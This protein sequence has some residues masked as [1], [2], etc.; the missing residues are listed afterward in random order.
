MYQEFSKWLER[1]LALG[2]P[3]EIIAVHFN[4]YEEANHNWSIQF[5][6]TGSFDEED[7]DWACDEVFSTGEDLYRWKK[8]TDWESALEEGVHMVQEYLAEGTYA[9]ML[10]KYRAVG[11]GFVDG[12]IEVLYRNF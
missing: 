2:L 4:L 5:V 3:D 10:K 9:D 7:E 6:G 11:I 1:V 12:D 8:D